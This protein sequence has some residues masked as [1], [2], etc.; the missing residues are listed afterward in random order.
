MIGGDDLA[1]I[2]ELTAALSEA[3]GVRPRALEWTMDE[4]Y[5]AEIIGGPDEPAYCID[6]ANILIAFAG[7]I[8]LSHPVKVLGRFETL[9]F[10]ESAQSGFTDQGTVELWA[11]PA[12]FPLIELAAECGGFGDFLAGIMDAYCG[13]EWTPLLLGRVILA[14]ES[15]QRFA[16]L[17][18][19]TDPE[20]RANFGTR[21][22][23]IKFGTGEDTPPDD[24]A[25]CRL[26]QRTIIPGEIIEV[27]RRV[28][29]ETGTPLRFGTEAEMAE[30]LAD[31]CEENG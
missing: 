21:D 9:P 29:G 19:V 5:K 24:A 3:L 20:N 15:G 22:C 4:L 16:I 30:Y 31:Y 10:I 23:A 17:E 26:Q 13:A 12:D 8:D 11:T 2:R 27:I 14:H 18:F 7:S 6:A 28:I 25:P 1:T